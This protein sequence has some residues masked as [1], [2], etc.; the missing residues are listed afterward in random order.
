MFKSFIKRLIAVSLM[1]GICLG[2][3]FYAVTSSAMAARAEKHYD[4]SEDVVLGWMAQ[5][6]NPPAN[7]GVNR[8]HLKK[9]FEESGDREGGKQAISGWASN[10][11]EMIWVKYD[12]GYDSCSPRG[13]CQ[14]KQFDG[15]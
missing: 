13:N 12:N 6:I 9:A 2:G 10:G 8:Y 7:T 15:L 5:N 1:V 14:W 11:Q 3:S 4:A